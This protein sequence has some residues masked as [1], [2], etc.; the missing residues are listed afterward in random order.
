MKVVHKEKNTSYK[1]IF[2]NEIKEYINVQSKKYNKVALITDKNIWK[3]YK[4]ILQ[5][6]NILN[7]VIN[8]GEK[9][10][11]IK[12]KNNIEDLLLKN[13]FNRASL[14]IGVGGGVI[15]DL[16]GFTA[17]TFMRGVDL[18]HIP[19]SLVA[20]VDSSIGGKTAIDNKYGKNLIGT[21][22][23]PK[24]IIVNLEFLQSLPNKEIRQGMAEIIKYSIIDDKRLFDTLCKINKNFLGNKKN[25]IRDIIRKCMEI[26]I[27][28]VQ[29]DY[30]E[31]DLRMILNFGHTI[32]H[33]L[34][35]LFDYKKSHGDCIGLGM[36]VEARLG[37]KMKILLKDD[38]Q[39]IKDVLI[40]YNLLNLKFSKSDIEKLL[41]NMRMDKKNHDNKITFS[42]PKNIGKMSKTKNKYSIKVDD[43]KISDTL[44]EIINEIK[45]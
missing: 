35:K 11:S 40:R 43:K 1:I 19:T 45:N 42:L 2:S 36:L 16:V 44:Y 13:S 8:P 34:E 33:G 12:I 23:N 17:S 5:N 21:F 18:V 20:I 31:S 32:G 27:K 15:G 25:T 38:Y 39:K 14:I 30:R 6:K 10:K 7:I 37:N 26:K 3:H 4:K 22:Y 9:S 41:N 24:E 29:N 28:T